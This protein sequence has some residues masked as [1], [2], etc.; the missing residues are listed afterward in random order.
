MVETKRILEMLSQTGALHILWGIAVSGKVDAVSDLVRGRLNPDGVASER[1]IKKAR[2][3]LIELGLTREI[4]EDSPPFR[5][6]IHP[7]DP[8]G[9]QV[10][11]KLKEILTIINSD[12]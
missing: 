10:I 9:L 5:R 11:E 4:A 6:T 12:R 3:Y 2:D 1:A 7:T 8:K